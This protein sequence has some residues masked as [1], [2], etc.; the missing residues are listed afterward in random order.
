MA[1]E[2]P[3]QQRMLSDFEVDC[4]GARSPVHGPCGVPIDDPWP[5]NVGADGSRSESRWPADVPVVVAAQS[6]LGT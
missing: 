4:T 2:T 6:A 5:D 1:Q 3:L